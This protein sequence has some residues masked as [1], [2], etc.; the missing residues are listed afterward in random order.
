VVKKQESVDPDGP[1]SYEDSINE[2]VYLSEVVGRDLEEILRNAKVQ[3]ARALNTRPENIYIKNNT[4][5]VIASKERFGEN[6]RP[7][8]W[9]SSVNCGLVPEHL[10]L[11]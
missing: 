7:V 8:L 5:L 6:P 10:R 2:A 11:G 3:A 1:P 4:N 9:R